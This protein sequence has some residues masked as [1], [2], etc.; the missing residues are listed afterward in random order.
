MP[1]KT[2]ILIILLA[3]ITG[4]LI[5]LAVRNETVQNTITQDTI[6]PSPT[7]TQPYALLSFSSDTLDLSQ[8][9]ANQT[10]D[11]VI[12]TN[13]K[14]VAGAQIELTFDPVVFTN[15]RLIPAENP[16]FGPDAVVLFN[17]VDQ[18]QGRASY[19]VG[20]SADAA[21]KTGAGPVVR[22]QFTANKAAGVANSSITFE[23]KSAVTTK[24][25]L[26]SVLLNTFPL[27]VTLT[28]PAQ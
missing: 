20:L 12:D 5:F 11:V 3:A 18:E 19:A 4:L 24:E 23:Q 15:V 8:L 1:K 9:S 26:G 7:S 27:Q 28:S 22:L 17:S 2:T 21:E 13:G 14:P 6:T 16:F 10:V 25:S